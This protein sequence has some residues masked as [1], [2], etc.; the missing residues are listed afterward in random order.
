MLVIKP[1]YIKK[2]NK[3]VTVMTELPTEPEQK[4]RKLDSLI[5]SEGIVYD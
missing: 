4:K 2:Q 1:K 5:N 3:S